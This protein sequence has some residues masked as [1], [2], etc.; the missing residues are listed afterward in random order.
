MNKPAPANPEL[1]RKNLISALVHGLIAIGFMV[2]FFVA[3][4]QRS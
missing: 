3:Q 4:S 1:A 2:L